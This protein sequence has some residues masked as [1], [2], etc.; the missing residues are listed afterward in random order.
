VTLSG[1]APAG[2]IV[3]SLTN[4]KPGVAAVPATI[5]VPAG[6]VSASAVVPTAAVTAATVALVNATANE[7]TQTG[8][9]IVNPVPAI[10]INPGSLTFA[11]LPVGGT[12]TAQPIYVRNI[13]AVPLT[14]IGVASSGDFGWTGNCPLAPATL[15]PGAICTINVTF[16]PTAGGTR[17]GVLTITSDVP[18]SPHVIPLSGNAYVPTPAIDVASAMEFGSLTL[19]TTYNRALRVTSTGTAPL[20]ISAASVGPAGQYDF[21]IAADDCSGRTL[22]PGAYCTLLVNFEPAA[23]GTRAAT[24]TIAHNAP[25]GSSAVALSGT[26]VKPR[27]GYIP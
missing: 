19:G 24:L 5:A 2:G 20:V 14:L 18:G 10:S 4:D 15:A 22:S 9:L 12:S 13:G 16:A 27:G 3:V 23:V 1:P 21:S 6:S 25:G 8:A 7:I 26:G 17:T 11:T